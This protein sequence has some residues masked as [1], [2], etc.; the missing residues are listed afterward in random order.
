VFS[1]L[2]ISDFDIWKRK[3]SLVNFAKLYPD[4]EIIIATNKPT[5]KD[6]GIA[7]S[8]GAAEYIPLNKGKDFLIKLLPFL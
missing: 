3:I 8:Q 5:Y 6:A 4:A 7:I 1:L 2:L